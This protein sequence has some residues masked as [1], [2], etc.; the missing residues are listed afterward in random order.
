M[1][2]RGGDDRAV[3]G[4]QLDVVLRSQQRAHVD[5]GPRP[6]AAA[7]SGI[8][9]AGLSAPPSRAVQGFGVAGLASSVPRPPESGSMKPATAPPCSSPNSRAA[10]ALAT[11]FVR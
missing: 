4:E 9:S 10:S 3:V 7:P 1:M 2:P 8:A 6:P 5:G 11:A